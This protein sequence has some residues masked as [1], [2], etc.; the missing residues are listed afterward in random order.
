M[1]W[2][3]ERWSEASVRYGMKVIEQEVE[4]EKED[5]EES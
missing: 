3:R 4:E 2:R 1:S 5:E